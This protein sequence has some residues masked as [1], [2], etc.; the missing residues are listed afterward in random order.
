MASLRYRQRCVRT[1]ILGIDAALVLGVLG[2]EVVP[3][4]AGG[5]CP[6]ECAVGSVVI[7]E[8]HEA[9][10]SGGALGF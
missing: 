7:V 5:G 4:D 8:V 10:V 1:V 6:S 9:A 2:G 3:D